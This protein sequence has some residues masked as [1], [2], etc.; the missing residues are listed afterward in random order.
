MYKCLKNFKS[1][2][3]PKCGEKGTPIH[4]E[5]TYERPKN[6]PTDID[7]FF[8]HNISG[9]SVDKTVPKRR[10]KEQIKVLILDA[11]SVESVSTNELYKKLGYSGNAPKSFR[12]CIEELI[13]EGKIRYSLNNK[14]DSSNVLIKNIHSF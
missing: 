7:A 10:T 1:K 4:E 2:N 13:A 9:S 6:N 5:Q 3:C 12:S 8:I 14:Q 11:L